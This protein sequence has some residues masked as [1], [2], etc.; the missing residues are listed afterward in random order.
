MLPELIKKAY[1]DKVAWPTSVSGGATPIGDYNILIK[2][3]I[4]NIVNPVIALM[5]AV[6]VI[7]FLWGVFQFV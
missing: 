2:N 3:I 1:A 5:V 7:Y 4:V 6:A